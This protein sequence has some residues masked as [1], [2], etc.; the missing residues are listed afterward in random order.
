ML[1]ASMQSFL[2]FTGTSQEKC[3]KTVANACP[4][5]LYASASETGW[6]Q[7]PNFCDSMKNVLVLY[8]NQ[9][10]IQRPVLMFLGMHASHFTIKL[11]ELCKEKQIELVI[12]L[13]NAMFILQPL[14]PAV[15]RSLKERWKEFLR[16]KD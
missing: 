3:T 1:L 15:F 9:N 7:D 4:D 10:N 14:D 6:M 2:L 11:S 16:K 8:L 5:S 12:L 13:P